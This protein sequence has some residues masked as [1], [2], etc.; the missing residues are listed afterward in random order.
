[1][2]TRTSGIYRIF[3]GPTGMTYIGRSTNIEKRIIDHRSKLRQKKRTNLK[4]YTFF[5]STGGTG[6]FWQILEANPAN[7]KQAEIDWIRSIPMDRRLNDIQYEYPTRVNLSPEERSNRNRNR[8]ES[9]FRNKNG[10]PGV[11]LQKNGKFRYRISW[12]TGPIKERGFNT[13]EDAHNARQQRLKDLSAGI[14]PRKEKW[15]RTI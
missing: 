10:Y 13:A 4:F 8:A 11:Y 14:T 12:P 9:I 1:M 7:P 5:Y 15:I 6:W 3:H 2:K